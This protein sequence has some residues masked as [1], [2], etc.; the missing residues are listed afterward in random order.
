MLLRL[1]RPQPSKTLAIDSTDKDLA[2][3]LK[4]QDLGQ[5]SIPPK[6]QITVGLAIQIGIGAFIFLAAVVGVIVYFTSLASRISANSTNIENI[7]QSIKTEDARIDTSYDRAISCIDK[8]IDNLR[9][10]IRDL[11]KTR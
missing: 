9:I 6:G 7:Q 1:P 10:E 11:I 4:T 3:E 8:Q 2:K 5:Q